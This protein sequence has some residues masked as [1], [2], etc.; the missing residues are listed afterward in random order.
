M[1]SN[2]LPWIGELREH[3]GFK[4][5]DPDDA[6]GETVFGISKTFHPEMFKDGPPTWE[7]AEAFYLALWIRNGCDALEFPMDVIHGDA[8]VNPGE[9]AAKR[10]RM[11]SGEHNDITRRGVEYC[12]LRLRYYQ[13]R[14]RE[15]PVKLKYIVG[16]MDRTLDYLERTI[17]N[18]WDMEV[19]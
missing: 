12:V 8:C 15:N 7:Q 6:G 13:A 1:R 17:I 14:V 9:G 19:L 11:Q 16:W 3:E 10:F 5:N 18:L 4:S 2:F